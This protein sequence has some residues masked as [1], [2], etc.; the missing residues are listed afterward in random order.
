MGRYGSS[1]FVAAVLRAIPAPLLRRLDAW[2]H[3]KA[4]HRRELRQ[5]AWLQRQAAAV[6][7]D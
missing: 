1:S 3:R 2:S 7:R 5:Q 4:L 6:A